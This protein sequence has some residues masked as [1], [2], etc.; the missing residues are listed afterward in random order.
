M[1]QTVPPYT[2]SK[3]MAFQ[4][5]PLFTIFLRA[6]ARMGI[7]AESAPATN[8]L[9]EERLSAP[10]EQTFLAEKPGLASTA[11]DISSFFQT[12]S[13]YYIKNIAL[14]KNRA[15]DV[16]TF[17]IDNR[18]NHL[19]LES[20][21][22]V[23]R[24]ESLQSLHNRSPMDFDRLDELKTELTKLIQARTSNNRSKF[25]IDEY[26]RLSSWLE[27]LN[28][29]WY[30]ER[31]AFVA[32]FGEVEQLLAAPDWATQLRNVLGIAHLGGSKTKPLPVVL[33]RYNLVRVEQAARKA[34]IAA[35]AATPSVLEAGGQSG[36]SAAFL[37]F[38]KAA[39]AS[40]PFAFGATVNLAANDALD[41]K[42]EFLHLRIE[43]KLEDFAMIGQ[44]TDV[45][46]ETQLATAR[47]QH[48][49]LIEQDFLYRSDMP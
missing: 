3:F 4:D 20:H 23:V 35:W 27:R 28:T 46:S 29:D 13:K 12:Y 17:V 42:S 19:T 15:A 10:R 44:L 31:P 30:D 16:A 47:R 34:R 14:P 43:Y 1:L 32:P 24:L 6:T 2:N 38:P 5:N 41:F 25:D 9:L 8:F 33:L 11:W 45:V 49:E 22:D 37:P 36:P 39:A 26:S 48:F 40:N 7:L 21:Q 18:E